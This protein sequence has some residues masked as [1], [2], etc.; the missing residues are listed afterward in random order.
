MKQFYFLILTTIAVL[1]CND[2]LFAQAKGSFAMSYNNSGVTNTIYFYVPANYDSTK[3]Y[4]MLFGF[5]GN[6]MPGSDMRDLLNIGISSNVD[7]IICCPDINN[8]TSDGT[9]INNLINASLSYT[10]STYKID[11]NKI[12][13]TGF[14]MGG[15][16]AFQ[17]G[18]IN[19]AIFKGIIGIS[20]AIGSAQFTQS[21]WDNITK[22]RMAT[23]DG[24]L[25]FNYT[26]VKALMN[27]I[28]SKGG[29]IL[30]IEKPGMD[31]T[32]SNGYFN[33]QSFKDDYLK[34]YNYVLNLTSDVEN[35]NPFTLDFSINIYPNPATENVH[36]QTNNEN[37]K[38]IKLFNLHGQLIQEYFT[39]DFSVANLPDGIYFITTKTD[40]TTFTN[41]L[42]KQ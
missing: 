29:N 25:D 11:S 5:H 2:N 18:L 31:H 39:N 16:I 3:T 4:P 20:P 9:R 35:N 19:P 37:I 42:I 27:D 23:I 17:L 10:R 30:Y 6:G 26:V 12:I 33:T 22:V 15:S 24:T 34:C 13:A 32:G 36:L 14:S 7:A 8:I 1:F 21:M 28:N 41:K 40:K 38:S